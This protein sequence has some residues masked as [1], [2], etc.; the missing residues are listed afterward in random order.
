MGAK[1]PRT[2]ILMAVIEKFQHVLS[3]IR[4]YKNWPTLIW[5]LT[6]IMKKDQ[7]MHSREGSK[8][9]VQNIFGPHFV[10]VH[11]MFARDDYQ[12]SSVKLKSNPTVLD[13][14][15]NIGAF[16][17]LVA[18]KYKDAKIFAYE[19][20]EGNRELLIKNIKLGSLEKRVFPKSAALSD[21]LGKKTF[22][23]SHA[24]DSHS[25]L[26]EFAGDFGRV[27]V[28]CVTLPDI[29]QE[30][31]IDLVDLLKL[32]IEG[33]EYD[34]LYNLPPEVL[35]KIGY[36]VLEIHDRQGHQRADLVRFLEDNNFT[37]TTSPQNPRVFITRNNAY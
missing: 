23:L 30:N 34:V 12:L 15:A 24:E 10:V 25:L 11:E 21:R 16:S 1:K 28:T 35:A 22:F 13:I 5:P 27:E 9:Y 4:A 2:S 29:L 7:I 31:A 33:M 26:P 32:D 36:L 18:N 17:I 6:R 8:I 37:I 3:R 19:P 14:G 20:E